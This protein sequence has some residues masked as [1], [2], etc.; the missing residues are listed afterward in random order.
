MPAS[1]A[2]HAEVPDAS[3]L[4]RP[5]AHAVQAP[6]VPAAATLPY[7]PA[8]QAVHTETDVAAER[9]LYVPAAQDVQTAE[10]TAE[11]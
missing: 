9:L 7:D 11:S 2:V 3:A 10:V 6:E 4:Y 1:Q 5:A 8:I